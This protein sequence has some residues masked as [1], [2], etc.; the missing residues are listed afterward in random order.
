MGTNRRL[1][2]V[3]SLALASFGFR[4]AAM[5]RPFTE[6]PVSVVTSV[7]TL[8]GMTDDYMAWLAGPW[9]QLMEAEK[10]AGVVVD[11]RVF[12]ATP[13]HPGEPDL[14]LVVAY[15]NFAAFDGLDAKLDP[16]ME[17]LVGPSQKA[18]AEFAARGKMRTI[19]GEQVIRELILK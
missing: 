8:D 5:D 1:W 18:N 12:S 17:K 6:G 7:R 14:Y 15:K 3:A 2:I 9:K 19:L 4:A 10:K 13:R 16:I 11:Y